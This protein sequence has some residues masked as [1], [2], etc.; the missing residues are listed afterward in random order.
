MTYTL[1]DTDTGNLLGTYATEQ[2]A[3]IL[4]Q[5]AIAA[6]G[7]EYADG[8]VLG[9]EDAKGRTTLIAEGEGLAKLALAFTLSK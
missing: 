1:M 3:L 8:L 4:V 5:G 6:Y 2:E 9:G 7:T